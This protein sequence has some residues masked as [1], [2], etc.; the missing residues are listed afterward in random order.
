MVSLL[1]KKKYQKKIFFRNEEENLEDKKFKNL[2]VFE[3]TEDIKF[4]RNANEYG[5]VIKNGI[6]LFEGLQNRQ[7]A[8]IK[9]NVLFNQ[10]IWCNINGNLI[11]L[12]KQFERLCRQMGLF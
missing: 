7:D 1:E 11:E 2:K 8:C 12:E 3:D 4:I 5:V 10:E 9:I 6:N